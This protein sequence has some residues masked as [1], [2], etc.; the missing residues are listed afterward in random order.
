M[1]AKISVFKAGEMLTSLIGPKQI[2]TRPGQTMASTQSYLGGRQQAYPRDLQNSRV[3]QGTA[4]HPVEFGCISQREQ[5]A[6][7]AV[8]LKV[9]GGQHRSMHAEAGPECK[10]SHSESLFCIARDCCP[11]LCQLARRC[12]FIAQICA[13]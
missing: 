5:V 2:D 10:E 9:K 8:P 12:K 7:V 4:A 3:L 13:F 11:C 6:W 1:N